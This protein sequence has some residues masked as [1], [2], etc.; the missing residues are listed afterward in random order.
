MAQIHRD[1]ANSEL[2]EPKGIQLATSG[3]VD[4]GKVIVALGD[5]TSEIRRLTPDDMDD[6]PEGDVLSGAFVNTNMAT[7]TVDVAIEGNSLYYVGAATGQ[8]VTVQLPPAATVVGEFVT[9]KRA[10]SNTAAGSRVIIAPDGAEMIEGAVGLELYYLNNSVVLVSNGTGWAIAASHIITSGWVQYADATYTAVSPLA[11]T[12][13]AEAKLTIDG[14]GPLTTTDQAALQGF[15]YWD[16]SA[17]KF[18]QLLEGQVSSL[19]LFFITEPSANDTSV[20]VKFRITGGINIASQTIRLAKG[21]G[22]RQAI[23]VSLPVYAD[24]TSLANGVEIYVEAVGGNL[25]VD[26]V[27]LM[28]I[29]SYL[30]R[31]SL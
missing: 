23:T 25:E 17:N 7:T 15:D 6:F 20:V 4:E 11:I 19:R 2:H 8:T 26:T 21:S 12:A 3:A 27:S 18:Q 1:L 30:P 14:L 24:S 29:D 28:I 9:V 10:D 5:G 31:P 22:A 16:T 13:G